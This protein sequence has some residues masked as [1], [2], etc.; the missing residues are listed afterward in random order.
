MCH[1]AFVILPSLRW[2]TV[3]NSRMR[4]GEWLESTGRHDGKL[5]AAVR[6]VT[7]RDVDVAGLY[8]PTDLD[9]IEDWRASH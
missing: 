3:R 7:D 5:R 4:G 1:M 2:A 9:S 6:M 8:R